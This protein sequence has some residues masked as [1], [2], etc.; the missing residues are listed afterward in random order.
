DQRAPLRRASPLFRSPP[1]RGIVETLPRQPG[2]TISR[3]RVNAD[4]QQDFSLHHTLSLYLI[5][6]LPL[7]DPEDPDFPLD[8]LTLVESIVENPEIIL[9]AQLNR[10]KSDRMAELRAE[11]VEYEQRMAQLDLVEYPKPRREF[12]YETFNA[13]AAKHPWVGENNIQPK[14]IAREMFERW[15]SFEDYIRDYGLQRSEGILLRHLS[16]VY[17][18]LAQTVPENAKT[19]AVLEIE[20]YLGELIRNIDSS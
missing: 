8:V 10:A 3:L 20:N 14:S 5:D 12:I 7:L 6:T 9:R 19:D 13:F 4:L 1:E 17:K 18:A 15:M 11:G 16:G 2:E